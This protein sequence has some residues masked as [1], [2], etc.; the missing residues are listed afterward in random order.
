[1][2]H[3]DFIVCSF[4][5]NSIG[6][7]R[8][9]CHFIFRYFCYVD[10]N[11]TRQGIEAAKKDILETSRFAPGGRE[12]LVW[13]LGKDYFIIRFNPVLRFKTE[14]VFYFPTKMIFITI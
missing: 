6:L 10:L 13:P 4:M 2:N 1:M 8:V 12:N 3:S 11:E 14:T 7:K 9:K 5:E